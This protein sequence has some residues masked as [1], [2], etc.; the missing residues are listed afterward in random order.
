M[1]SMTYHR[2]TGDAQE[3]FPS[4]VMDRQEFRRPIFEQLIARAEAL[5]SNETPVV[6]RQEHSPHDLV[7]HHLAA[8]PHLVLSNAAESKRLETPD[9]SNIPP[10]P[11]KLSSVKRIVG[12]VT[13]VGNGICVVDNRWVVTGLAKIPVLDDRVEISGEFTAC[14]AEQ[15]KALD[16]TTVRFSIVTQMGIEL[17]AAL[18]RPRFSESPGSR[19]W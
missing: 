4:E 2:R 12:M 10:P 8:N 15:F 6:E 9:D 17:E 1:I 16:A 18:K 13:A 7:L 19:G 14:K 3:S 11:K 5:E